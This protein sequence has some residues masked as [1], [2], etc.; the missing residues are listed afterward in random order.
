[1]KNKLLLMSTRLKMP[2]PRKNYIIREALFSK[3]NEMEEYSLILVKGG[4]GTGK[5]TLMASFAKE[6]DL[7]TIKWISLD[8]SCNNV[9][10]FWGYFIEAVEEYLGTEKQ[11]FMSLYET[12]FQKNNL[13]QLLTLLI[14]ALDNQEEIFI[15]VD[16]FYHVSDEFLVRTIEFFLKNV[17]D[18]VHL[19]LLTRQE[20]PFYTGSLNMEGRLLII[21]EKDLKLPWE[22]GIRF[23]TDT[24]KLNFDAE[25]LEWINRVSEG[26]IGGLQLVAAA[27]ASK[28]EAEIKGLNLETRLVGEYLTKEIYEF[29][30]PEEKDFLLNTSIL[31]YFNEEICTG[32]IKEVNFREIMDGLMRKNILITC[33][34]EEKGLYRYHN[35]L[36]EYLKTRFKSFCKERQIQLHLKAAEILKKLGDWNQ[37]I[38]QLLQAEDYLNAMKYVLELPQNMNLFSYVDRIPAAF[39]TQSPD[40]AYQCFFYHY[41]NMEFEKCRG[42][43]EVFKFKMA[44]DQTFSAFKFSN[45]FVE[46]S[47]A[48]NEIQIRPMEETEKL[49]LKDTTKALIFIRDASFLYTQYRY[50][51]A[52]VYIDKAMSYSVSSS[53]FYIVFFS[54]SIKSQIL[55]DIGEL[56]KC[57][58]MYKEM[59][60]ILI[61]NKYI[62]MFST[63]FFIG[64][65][66]VCLKLMDLRGAENCLCKAAEYIA[67]TVTP[68][69]IGYKYN[70]AEYKFIAGET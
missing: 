30:S 53:N 33:I 64:N 59:S 63:S 16:D 32:L 38:D 37:Y 25:T 52:L 11:D 14:N 18:N 65:T 26:W 45:I 70:L 1:M 23:L 29:L 10:L 43:Y 54:F 49:P 69:V 3:L 4:A 22:A 2:Q 46:D 40:F 56:C 57:E 15:V 47:F 50:N 55:E 42:L 20:L 6:K 58:A 68:S 12:N 60:K 8:E 67:E 61:S 21:D 28:S 17:S 51:E 66:G 19:I 44:E 31:A 48:L 24:L 5:T 35:I 39:I 36:R 13:K 7:S 34:D 27:V 9:F 41:A 62:T